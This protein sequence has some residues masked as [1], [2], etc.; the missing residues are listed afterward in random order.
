AQVDLRFSN[1]AGELLGFRV[2]AGP[3]DL[4]L[5]RFLD[6][7]GLEQTGRLSAWR[8][9]FLAA[10]AR[11]RVVRGPVLARAFARLALILRSLVKPRFFLRLAARGLT[12]RP[13][14]RRPRS[15][16]RCVAALRRGPRDAGRSR[17]GRRCGGSRRRRLGGRSARSRRFSRRVPWP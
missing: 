10:R 5:K 4:T 12:R 13:R 11:P 16:A 2:S 3:G 9:A 8:S 15:L 6:N 17:A 1:T 14:T 7:A